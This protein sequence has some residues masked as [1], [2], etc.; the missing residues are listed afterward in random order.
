MRRSGERPTE[1]SSFTPCCGRRRRASRPPHE[2]RFWKC[3]VEREPPRRDGTRARRRDARG[4]RRPPSPRRTGSRHSRGAAVTIHAATR[5]GRGG[6]EPKGRGGGGNARRAVNDETRRDAARARGCVRRRS[7]DRARAG[8]PLP[9]APRHLFAPATG[10]HARP[11]DWRPP[12]QSRHHDDRTRLAMSHRIASQRDLDATPLRSARARARRCAGTGPRFSHTKQARP[13]AT[14]AAVCARAAH[15][16]W[17][18]LLLADRAEDG[19]ERDMDKA[20]VVA[21]DA[22]L[23]LAQRLEEHH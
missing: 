19:H 18:C 23:E 2:R 7:R 3:V 5:R 9:P 14:K 17:F 13:S 12:N 15:L 4:R 6:A 21:A 8:S 22:E 11:T 20:E 1:R 10:R 16:S